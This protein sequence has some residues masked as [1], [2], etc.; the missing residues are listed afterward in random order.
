MDVSKLQMIIIIIN[1]FTK[2]CNKLANQI[3]YF[4]RR[5]IFQAKFKCTS[6]Q[7]KKSDLYLRLALVLKYTHSE[8]Q[9]RTF[10]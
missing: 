4:N 7:L 9:T 2:K 5:S 3:N 6:K 8:L 10:N 1:W